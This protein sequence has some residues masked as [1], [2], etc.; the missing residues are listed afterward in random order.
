[1]LYFHLV[2]R[3]DN[4]RPGKAAANPSPTGDCDKD[5]PPA[6]C[7]NASKVPENY[8]FCPAG[9]CIHYR[10]ELNADAL[11]EPYTPGQSTCPAPIHSAPKS[12]QLAD[13][14]TGALLEQVPRLG[15]NNAQS[16][17]QAFPHFALKEDAAKG[18][19]EAAMCANPES[20]RQPPWGAITAQAQSFQ[21]NHDPKYKVEVRETDPAAGAQPVSYASG[22]GNLI[23]LAIGLLLQCGHHRM[24]RWR[25]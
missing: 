1:M 15:K 10:V 23:D 17:D 14:K 25:V 21:V 5:N 6:E 24:L 9:G 7:P 8:Y 4:G 22:P 3:V 19:T 18:V 11:S 13:L 20:D 12:Y 2:Q 16:P